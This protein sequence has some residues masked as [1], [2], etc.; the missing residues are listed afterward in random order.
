[1]LELNADPVTSGPSNNTIQKA[2]FVAL[3]DDLI[4]GA[5]TDI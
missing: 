4:S 1:M 5:Q 3:Y 2:E